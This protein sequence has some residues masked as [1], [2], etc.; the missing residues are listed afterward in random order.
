M[1]NCS[2][3]KR[4]KAYFVDWIFVI[5]TYIAIMTVMMISAYLVNLVVKGNVLIDVTYNIIYYTSLVL[6][7]G[8]YPL[9]KDSLF[10]CG[11]IGCKLN[12]IEILNYDNTRPTKKQMII[13]GLFFH[14]FLIDYIFFKIDRKQISLSDRISKT[15]MMQI[16]N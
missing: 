2:A 13:R 10:K 5:I 1:I 16:I 6:S 12:K 14:L 9:F 11:S 15:K 8:I 7:I 3:E 4:L